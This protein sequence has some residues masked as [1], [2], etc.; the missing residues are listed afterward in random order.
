MI[1]TSGDVGD[2]GG[3]RLR[4]SAAATDAGDELGHKPSRLV[5]MLGYLFEDR[6]LAVAVERLAGSSDEKRS[7]RLPAIAG[8]C[9][10]EQVAVF[11]RPAQ[12]NLRL[13]DPLSPFDNR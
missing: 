9:V 10:A 6:A 12:G 2:E 3:H 4:F 11:E 1:A 7:P 5:I 8:Q 13:H